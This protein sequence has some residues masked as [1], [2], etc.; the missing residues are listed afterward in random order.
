MRIRICTTIAAPPEVVWAEVEAIEDHPRWMA[1]AVSITFADERRRGVG[2]E[3]SCLTKVGPLVTTDRF[4]ITAW[5]PGARMAIEHRGA[6][7]GQGEFRLRARLGRRT[8]FC[9]RERLHFPW[10][11]GGPL[12]EVL[13]W[14][15]LR[16]LWRRNLR[17]L[18]GRIEARS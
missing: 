5:E 1:D 18:R 15:V 12:G 11:M 3:F 17:R 10:W 13:A 4:V 14:P 6:V 8:R 2:T 7:K 9:W 16:M